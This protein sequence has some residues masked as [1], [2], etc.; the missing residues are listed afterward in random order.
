MA[1][2]CWHTTIAGFLFLVATCSGASAAYVGDR[3]F[4]STLAP[5]VPTPADFSKPPYFVK[6]PDTATTSEIDIPNTYSRLVTRTW[7]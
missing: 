4:P 7:H 3:F 1:R 6:L 5:V 2:T